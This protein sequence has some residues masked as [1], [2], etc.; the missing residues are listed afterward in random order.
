MRCGNCGMDA[1]AHCDVL[2]S[3][4]CPN[5]APN[6][7]KRAADAGVK[8]ERELPVEGEGLKKLFQEIGKAG[9]YDDVVDE[10]DLLS[11]ESRR[12]IL[13]AKFKALAPAEW[14]MKRYDNETTIKVDNG[15]L[16]F[17]LD[18][19]RFSSEALVFLLDYLEGR[20]YTTELRNCGHYGFTIYDNGMIVTIGRGKTRIE[21]VVRACVSL[22]TTEHDGGNPNLDLA[23]TVAVP[24]SE[25]AKI[26]EEGD[27]CDVC[28][29]PKAQCECVTIPIE[30]PPNPYEL[31][32]GVGNE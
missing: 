32:K 8:S 24:D 31:E 23:R 9:H 7:E 19:D 4:Y 17:K 20:K 26:W 21:A 11:S 6:T 3:G 13:L 5:A 16:V 28:D 1:H 30:G 12:S 27:L 18:D 10:S 25:K 22:W 15:W 29:L 14:C 2:G